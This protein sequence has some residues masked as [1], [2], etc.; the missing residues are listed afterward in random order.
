MSENLL[1]A[2]QLYGLAA[3]M[4]IS[5]NEEARQ[6]LLG[7]NDFGEAFKTV[8]IEVADQIT[9]ENPQLTP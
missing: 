6:V 9:Q 8:G 7:D 5:S 2:A 3:W 1:F 4:H